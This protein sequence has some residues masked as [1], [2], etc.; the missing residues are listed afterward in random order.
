[1]TGHDP[2]D[3]LLT[4]AFAADA[5]A[6]PP[7]RVAERVMARIRRRRR[8]RVVV[9]SAA[10]GIGIAVTA[11]ASASAIVEFGRWLGTL[12][13]DGAVLDVAAALPAASVSAWPAAFP[14]AAAL[15]LGLLGWFVC[16]DEESGAL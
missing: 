16:L 9:L 1:M 8:L 10:L 12:R 15:L 3:T 4:R 2:V 6:G 11:A 13:L 7:D 14:A 5:A